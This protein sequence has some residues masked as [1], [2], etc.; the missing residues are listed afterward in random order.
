MSPGPGLS[1]PAPEP[2]ARRAQTACDLAVVG[3]GPAGMAAAAQAAALGL[4]TVLIDEQAAPGGQ[5]YRNVEA[6]G[7]ARP[8]ALEA[9]GAGYAKGLAL[10]ARFRASGAHYRPQTAVWAIEENGAPGA[11]LGANLGL[12]E[13]LGRLPIDAVWI[14][15]E[16][17]AADV[18]TVA[19][20]ARYRD[21]G[22]QFLYA[23]ANAFLSHGAVDLAGLL[24]K[25]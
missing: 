20:M 23:H 8:G 14:D 3:A 12:V 13:S 18:E 7:Q 22:A 4:D 21:R 24:A 2:S 25:R 19:N 11:S 5:V 10:A 1:G 17:G 15:C 6:V 16:Q 9:L